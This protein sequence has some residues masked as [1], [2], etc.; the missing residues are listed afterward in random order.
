MAELN[1][2][3][4]TPEKTALE[5]KAEFVAMPLYDGEIGILPGHSPMIGRLGYGEMRIRAGGKETRYYVDGGFVQ[6]A[7]NVVS[8]LTNRAVLGTSV[9]AEAARKQL[10][11]ATKRPASTDEELEL[12]DRLVIQSR[13][14][15]RVAARA[16]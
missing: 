4:V 10:A 3:V 5:T 15:I 9:D 13:A 8:I 14:Q 11:A 6:V 16:K 2:I 12:R 1:C 7:D